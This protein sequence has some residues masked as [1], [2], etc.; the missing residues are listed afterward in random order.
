MTLSSD[1]V[2]AWR[3]SSKR[4]M[5]ESMGSSCHVCGYDTCTDALAFHH[6]EP[7]EK[8]LSFG[9]IRANPKS[10]AKIVEELRKCILVCHNCHSEI[11][12]GVIEWPE[13][14]SYFNEDFA[15]YKETLPDT[16]CKIC[17]NLKGFKSNYCSNSCYQRDKEI[18]TGLDYSLIPLMKSDGKTNQEIGDYF[19]IS[20]AAVRKRLSKFRP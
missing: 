4:R 5:V 12:A 18:S 7:H 20:E 16:F 14:K 2:K 3:K 10:W 6:L 13:I 8:E 15:E 9:A 11:H 1:K 17:G 19:G